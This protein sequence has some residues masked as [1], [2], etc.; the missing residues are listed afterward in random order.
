[1]IS[2]QD[3]FRQKRIGATIFIGVLI[4]LSCFAHALGID[5]WEK[6]VASPGGY[7][8]LIRKAE[9]KNKIRI[10]ARVNVEYA[11]EKQL[12]KTARQ[13]Q[14]DTIKSAQKRVMEDLG[15]RGLTPE[16]SRT[17]TY[18]PYLAL[19][20]DRAALDTLL[21]SEGITHI[22]ED[23]PVPVTQ[24]GWDIALIE[25][26]ALHSAGITA[27]G[28]TVAVLDTGVDKNH[29][30]LSGAIVEEACYSSNGSDADG[31]WSSL[32]LGGA[33]SSIAP[34]S[35]L[36]YASG[37]CPATECDHGT[38]VA[39]TIAGRAGVSGSPGP[40]VAPGASIIAIQVFSRF[41]SVAYCGGAGYTPC[42]L[43]YTSDQIAGL[44]RV[45]ALKERYAIASVNMSLGGGQYATPA[46]CDGDN[47][48]I[49]ATIDNLRAAGIATVA[50]SGNDAFCGSMSAPACIS[51]AISV[52]ATERSDTVAA[53]SNSASFLTLLAPGSQIT[54]SIPGNGWG[55]WSGTS[56]AAP[57]VSGSWA[58]LKSK[59]LSS[60]VDEILA[61][62]TSTGRGVVDSG[63]CS[64]VTKP[65]I[66][67]NKGYG[68]LG[69]GFALTLS[70][71]G[72]GAGT[73][74]SS[75][76][77]IDC[78]STCSA[79]FGADAQVTLTATPAPG[80]VFTGW[81]G[82]AWSGTGT[83]TVTMDGSKSIGASFNLGNII[84]VSRK[85]T[86]S[87][88]VASRPSG[89]SCPAVCS[90]TFLGD[91]SITLTPIASLGSTFAYW[92]GACN[93]ALPSCTVGMN[94]NTTV[95]AA[96]YL[97]KNA[98]FRLTT[99]KKRVSA[100]D[101]TILSSDGRIGCGTACGY[102][103]YPHTPVTLTATASGDAVF[104]GWSG[105]CSGTEATCTI[106]M[107]K[108]KTALASFAG[109]QKLTVT[110]RRVKGGDGT[111]TS[112]PA[113]IDCGD[114]MPLPLHRQ[115]ARD[116]RCHPFGRCT[117]HGL[118]RGLR[119][120]RAHVHAHHGQGK[121]SA[122][123]FH[124]TMSRVEREAGQ[125]DPVFPCQWDRG[126]F[127]PDF[128]VRSGSRLSP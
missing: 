77:G 50:A 112:D 93:D 72:S 115:Y 116:P 56:M 79:T 7:N 102:G 4:F 76:A 53:Y 16:R 125:Q 74:V 26:P 119:R 78:G 98:K 92:T 61:A 128:F 85:G 32:C 29:P 21:A 20:V 8:A 48:S 2:K 100:G 70:A 52:G 103:Y 82:E 97:T 117:F 99:A 88:T 96:F 83:C 3:D 41:E 91:Q 123:D 101:G 31:S 124:R 127:T 109:P 22:E 71:S 14:R 65:R 113:G 94:E 19:T 12:S 64:L 62:F 55:T 39:G 105:A 9:G 75:P 68:V 33:L 120:N 5:T 15:L 86:G 13:V 35:A 47:T 118:E 66:D 60:T 104:T 108:A 111:V 63:K 49:K 40:G 89:I 121:N 42:V 6:K 1:M 44:E 30:Y 73:V 37:N 110:K 25:A 126:L 114:T 84:T 81:S 17:Y 38:H 46:E 54:S 122:G 27:N 51:T 24:A 28:I 67:V 43:S 87:G 23:I 80:S 95:T 36:P 90:G 34:D 10:L 59:N 69:G 57:H 106:T 58:L 11:L 18:V 107:D 45:Y